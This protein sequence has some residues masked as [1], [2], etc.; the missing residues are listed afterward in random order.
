LIV[1]YVEV[2]LIRF[3][4]D[5]KHGELQEQMQFVHFR[6]GKKQPVL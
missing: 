5:E 1:K 6:N 2:G 3:D 4:K